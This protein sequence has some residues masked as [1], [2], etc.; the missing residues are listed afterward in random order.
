MHIFF[1]KGKWYFT[2]MHK[3]HYNLPDCAWIA[4]LEVLTFQIPSFEGVSYFLLMPLQVWTEVQT[5]LHSVG[6]NSHISCVLW[7]LYW[8]KSYQRSVFEVGMGTWGESRLWGALG[9]PEH[10]NL[11][12]LSSPRHSAKWCGLCVNFSRHSAMSRTSLR[13]VLRTFPD[14]VEIFRTS[15]F[16]E[17]SHLRFLTSKSKTDPQLSGLL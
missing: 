2:M 6:K 1:P 12:V 4:S 3:T 10:L 8:P 14:R 9:S 5:T 7:T 15:S 13:A 16:H 11:K 17:T